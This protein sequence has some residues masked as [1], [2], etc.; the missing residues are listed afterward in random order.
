[1]SRGDARTDVDPDRLVEIIGG[2]TL[3]AMMLR[4]DDD[5]GDDWVQAITDIIAHGVMA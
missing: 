1:M 4:P 2:A 5:L 3:L